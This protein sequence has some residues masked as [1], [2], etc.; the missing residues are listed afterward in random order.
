[1]ATIFFFADTWV[2]VSLVLAAQSLGLAEDKG[3]ATPKER[4][5]CCTH[6]DCG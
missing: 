3:K 6:C 1:M 4:Q 2:T 5:G